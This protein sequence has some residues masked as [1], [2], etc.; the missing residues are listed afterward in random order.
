[1]GEAVDI[2][3]SVKA[4]SRRTFSCQRARKLLKATRLTARSRNIHRLRTSSQQRDGLASA[5]LHR[6]RSPRGENFESFKGLAP[7]LQAAKT[8]REQASWFAWRNL[9]A[10]RLCVRILSLVFVLSGV[11]SRAT[12]RRSLRLRGWSLS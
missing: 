6:L 9:A 1:M 3:D 10:L 12:P 2:F 7:R 5:P 11:S 4:V 8:R